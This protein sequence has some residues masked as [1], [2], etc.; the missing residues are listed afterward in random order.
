M[1]PQINPFIWGVGARVCVKENTS[2]HMEL[3][4]KP[5][6]NLQRL[7]DMKL[8]DRFD[9]IPYLRQFTPYQL[10]ISKTRILIFQ[11]WEKGMIFLN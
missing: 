7:G 6:F 5:E 3:A 8:M 9:R 10:S 1:C 11:I 2:L 4:Q